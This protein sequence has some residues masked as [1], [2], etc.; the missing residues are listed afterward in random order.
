MPNPIRSI[1]PPRLSLKRW[2]DCDSRS[3]PWDASLSWSYWHCRHVAPGWLG[4]N[5]AL[6]LA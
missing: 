6:G 1:Y 5:L 2:S 4:V 3:T